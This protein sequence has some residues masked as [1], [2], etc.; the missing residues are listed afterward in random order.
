MRSFGRDLESIARIEYAR[1]LSLHREL[2][3]P[4]DDDARLNSRMRVARNF[5]SRFY[6]SS[7]GMHPAS[8]LPS[9]LVVFVCKVW[10][11]LPRPG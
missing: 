10:Y 8:A 4:F 5:C 9:C 7:S 3:R 6:R 2:K 11:S 1:R